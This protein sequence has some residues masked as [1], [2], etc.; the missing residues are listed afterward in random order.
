MRGKVP[1]MADGDGRERLFI[2][3][4]LADEARREIAA[5]LRRAFPD[6]V[7]GRAVP[8]AN[9]HLTLRF[10]GASTEAQ[11]RAIRDGL[12][13]RP[14]GGGFALRFGGAGAFPQVRSARVLWLGITDGI[15]PVRALA[16]RAEEVARAAGFAAEDRAFKAH[17][18][19]A[20]IHPPR[21]VSRVVESAPPLDLA[22]DVR[23]V[24]VY[25][26]HLGG[27]GARYEAVDRIPL[28]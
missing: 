16:A 27:G 8:A 12:R 7:P 4:P 23:E 14:L 26:S 11:H 28:G 1:T 22:M 9:W 24:V 2:A 6:G 25:R 10:L 5:Y 13:A 21:D 15:E 19:L 3:L 17:L 18:T 20:R